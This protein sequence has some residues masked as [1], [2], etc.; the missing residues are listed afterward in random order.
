MAWLCQIHSRKGHT[1]GSVIKPIAL[2]NY[3]Y[4][5]C[6]PDL[7]IMARSDWGHPR[8]SS[9][10]CLTPAARTCGCHHPSVDTSTSHAFCTINTTRPSLKHT[11]CT[12]FKRLTD[13][14]RCCS[15]RTCSLSAP[16]EVCPGN[17]CTAANQMTS[18]IV[19]GQD[20]DKSS[21]HVQNP[22]YKIITQHC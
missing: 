10:S 6:C 20:G 4:T 15:P 9:L 19:T 22:R 1:I 8:R 14:E 21:T 11:R 16:L 3:L 2:A 17:V 7:Q 5:L 13:E 12:T 18:Q